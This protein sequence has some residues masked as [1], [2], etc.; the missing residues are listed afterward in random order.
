MN[1]YSIMF[2]LLL[3]MQVDGFS[4]DPRFS[5]FYANPL[6]LA[7]SFAGATEEN[8]LVLNYRNQWPSIPGVFLTYSFSFDHYFA[9]FNSGVG[10]LVTHDRA[11]SGRLSNTNVGILYSYNIKIN[12]N[13][14]VRPGIQLYYTQRGLDFWRLV[15]SDGMSPGGDT[16]TIEQPPFE[17]VADI[18]AGAS[19]LAYTDRIWFGTTVDHILRP[20]QSMYGELSR[21]PIKISAFGGIQIIKKG[22]LFKPLEESLS[23]A[24]HF[25][26]Q[27]KFTQLDLGL[28]WFKSPLMFGFWYRG[29]PLIDD[30][31]DRDAV[32]LLVGYKTKYLHVGYSYDFTISQLVGATG[33]SH[34]ISLMYE[35]ATKKRKKR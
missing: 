19:I 34:E 25:E 26:N 35:F 22:R 6:Y 14:F 27:G 23:V 8:R 17:N 31:F 13:F 24:F 15:F 11:G 3:F 28:Y 4:Q 20:N 2:L 9:N 21:V 32:V 7:P 18:D 33:G 29:L 1:K 16:P 10:V 12:K 5:Q 30:G